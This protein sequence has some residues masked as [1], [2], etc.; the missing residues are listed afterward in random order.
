MPALQQAAVNTW[1]NDGSVFNQILTNQ[2]YEQLRLVFQEYN[3][4]TGR[5]VV[6]FIESKMTGNLRAAYIA[7][8]KC[9]VNIPFF[10]AEKL[11]RAIKA[12]GVITSDKTLIRIIVS[13][14]EVDLVHIK[15]EYAKNFK[16]ELQ[17]AI[18]RDKSGDYREALLLLVQGN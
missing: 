16:M 9:V 13:R 2:S 15:A 17:A 5:S 8:T 18:R 4:L 14:C 7:I 3:N 11:E 10:F 6:E 12:Q 1:S